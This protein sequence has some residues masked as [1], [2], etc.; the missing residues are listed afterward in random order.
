MG[1]DAPRGVPG[2]LLLPG[3]GAIQGASGGPAGPRR[4]IACSMRSGSS[5]ALCML[6]WWLSGGSARRAGDVSIDRNKAMPAS[7]RFDVSMRRNKR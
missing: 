1:Y 7:L 2:R 3:W 5:R 4:G 6:L